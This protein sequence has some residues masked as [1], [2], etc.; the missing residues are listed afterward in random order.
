MIY[1]LIHGRDPIP[2]RT[3]YIEYRSPVKIVIIIFWGRPPNSIGFHCKIFFFHSSTT[4]VVGGTKIGGCSN[5][6]IWQK[7]EQK[8]FPGSKWIA[9]NILCIGFFF[10]I[11]EDAFILC[12]GFFYRFRKMLLEAEIIDSVFYVCHHDYIYI[13]HIHMYQT[14]GDSGALAM[15]HAFLSHQQP[16]QEDLRK[17]PLDVFEALEWALALA[18]AWTIWMPVAHRRRSA[19]S[20][21]I[22]CN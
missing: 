17:L 11:P 21:W 5:P 9:G 6:W 15:L 2:C 4:P 1:T 19:K 12:I 10:S 16:S 3:T 18:W 7:P 20:S 8:Y 13:I 22:A 14:L